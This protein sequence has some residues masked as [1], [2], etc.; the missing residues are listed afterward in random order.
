MAACSPSR[1]AMGPRGKFLSRTTS[2]MYAGLRLDLTRSG[3]PTPGED[4][5][6]NRLLFK[7]RDF[8][9]RFMPKLD[10]AQRLGLPVH[11]SERAYVPYRIDVAL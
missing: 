2:G 3:S 8:D 11:S 7:F 9:R 1:S 4:A 5:T 10:T 6:A